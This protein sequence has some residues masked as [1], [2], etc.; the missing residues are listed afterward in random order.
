MPSNIGYSSFTINGKPANGGTFK[1]GDDLECLLVVYGDNDGASIDFVVKNALTDSDGAA[2]I[3]KS[4]TDGG[5]G[6]PITVLVQGNVLTAKFDIT[7]PETANLPDGSE[8]FYGIQMR[9]GTR[10]QTIEE[11]KLTLSQDVVRKND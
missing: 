6:Q 2:I 4:G 9:V 5:T 1:I 10:T 11:G 7:S 3:N 8:F